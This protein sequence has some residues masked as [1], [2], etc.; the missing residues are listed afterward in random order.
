M[1]CAVCMHIL[2]WIVSFEMCASFVVNLSQQYKINTRNRFSE[3]HLLR[4]VESTSIIIN[5]F[6][7]IIFPLYCIRHSQVSDF[8]SFPNANKFVYY[9]CCDMCLCMSMCLCHFICVCVWR[10]RHYSPVFYYFYIPNF[11]NTK[12]ESSVKKKAY[13]EFSSIHAIDLTFTIFYA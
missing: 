11:V 7:F 1:F 13:I 9:T 10:F 6:F 12:I 2:V 8:F 4:F 5:N 3:I